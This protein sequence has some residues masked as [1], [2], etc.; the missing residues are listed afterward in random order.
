VPVVTYGGDAVAA[1]LD[2]YPVARSWD[3]E[4]DEDDPG[5]DAWQLTGR[6]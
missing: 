4:D 6:R 5:E 3:D 2:R 1:D